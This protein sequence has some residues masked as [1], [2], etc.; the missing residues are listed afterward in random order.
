MNLKM[1]VSI[2]TYLAHF[3]KT[4]SALRPYLLYVKTDISKLIEKSSHIL[5]LIYT[6]CASCLTEFDLYA[7]IMN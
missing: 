1:V 5:A 4:H 6:R 2:Y 7:L 3:K